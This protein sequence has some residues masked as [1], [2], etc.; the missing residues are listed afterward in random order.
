MAQQQQACKFFCLDTGYISPGFPLA[1]P[2]LGSL[3]AEELSHFFFSS[4][5]QSEKIKLTLVS[6]E[7]C[8][9]YR[10]SYAAKASL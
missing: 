8:S 7:H 2:T 6:D 10:P 4:H 1:V 5:C 9:T 3:L